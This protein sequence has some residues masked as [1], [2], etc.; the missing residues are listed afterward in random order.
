MN[1]ILKTILLLNRLL[2]IKS[3]LRIVDLNRTCL[4]HL[5]AVSAAYRSKPTSWDPLPLPFGRPVSML[6]QTF[7]SQKHARLHAESQHLKIRFP[8]PLADQFHC[9]QTFI[10]KR[11]AR[12][13][14][15]WKHK[16][17]GYRVLWQNSFNV[18]KHSAE[19]STLAT[20]LTCTREYL[21]LVLRQKSIT[22][23]QHSSWSAR[24]GGMGTIKP[25]FVAS[26][27]GAWRG[28]KHVPVFLLM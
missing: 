4:L 7:P 18:P 28:L 19:N 13:H 5:T 15:R 1:L 2:N 16:D 20:I 24:L 6:L 26:F 10:R 12:A 17:V 3:G 21:I 14:A 27:Q 23:L 25:S 22:A 11:G 8:C 9:S